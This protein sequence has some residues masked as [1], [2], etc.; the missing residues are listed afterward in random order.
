MFTMEQIRNMFF[1]LLNQSAAFTRLQESEQKL[2]KINKTCIALD[3]ID[4]QIQHE[5]TEMNNVISERLQKFKEE[6][7]MMQK[8]NEKTLSEHR[9]KLQQNAE[10]SVKHRDTLEDQKR[11][12]ATNQDNLGKVGAKLDKIKENLQNEITMTRDEIYTKVEAV[13]EFYQEQCQ[14]LA[15]RIS[16]DRSFVQQE[17]SK[18]KEEFTKD[19]GSKIE[20]LIQF[21]R[22][23]TAEASTD[24]KKL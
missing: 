7:S 16:N 13:D 20:D 1:G 11:L 5:T 14:D 10:I 9:L 8:S 2:I 17:I 23:K 3:E 24:R 12:L 21:V 22:R 6:F 4:K 18:T 15:K 19:L